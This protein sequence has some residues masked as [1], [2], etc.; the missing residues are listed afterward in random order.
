A[1]DG[2]LTLTGSDL[3]ATSGNVSLSTNVAA[4]NGLTVTGGNITAAQNITLSGKTDSG[5]GYGLSLNNV[6]MT[7]TSG[8]ITASGEGFDASNGA[9]QVSGGNFSAQ[10]T[11]LNGTADRNN[12]GAVL[13]GNI[14]VKAGNLSL[15]GITV[16]QNG[17]SFTGLT[18]KDKSTLNINV[19]N[20]NLSLTGQA[21]KAEDA[22]ESLVLSGN[23]VGLNLVNTTL[24]ANHL[25]LKGSSAY[26]GSGFILNN[27]SLSGNIAQGNN[28]IFSSAGSAANVT[29]TLNI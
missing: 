25:T 12:K 24:S 6:N 11:V 14:N 15:T 18:V 1:E 16:Q 27:L 20:G 5:N 23:T 7:A 19:S 21:V 2:A 13:S 17:G 28:T 26:T 4:G 29:N 9:L 8:D 3:N 10:N 22:D